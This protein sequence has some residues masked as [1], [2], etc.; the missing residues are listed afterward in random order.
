MSPLHLV[1]A[2]AA[3][4]VAG[5]VNAVAGGGTLLSFPVLIALGLPP[6]S[7][8]ITN[9][10]ALTPGYLGGALAQRTAL[11][12]Q[13]RRVRALVGVA[14][15]GGL[16][17][18]I[19]LVLTSDAALRS[20]IP[21]FLL[22]ATLLLAGQD[23]I[24]AALHIGQRAGGP[25]PR[26]L[27]L[28]VFAVSVY[29]GYFGAGLSILL[30]AVLGIAVHD[31]LPRLNAV[32]QLLALVVQGTAALFFLTSHKIYWIVALV[33]AVTSLAGGALGGRMA[34]RVKPARLRAMVVV[35]GLAVSIGYAVKIW[36]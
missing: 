20:V 10:V 19:L 6:V 7:A 26:W 1:V 22:G 5:G 31:T 25:D 24:R 3:G 8:N 29:G 36:F 2:G 9:T 23:R 4:F 13:R 17:G 28:P 35:I 21:A 27:A 15:V 32:K 16:A 34:D 12:G 33:M 18:S 30:L 11:Q 14:A